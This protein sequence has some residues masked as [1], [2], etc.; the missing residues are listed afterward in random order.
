MPSFAKHFK[1]SHLSD[2]DV[3]IRVHPQDADTQEPAH[4]RAK[5]AANEQ[6]QQLA[7]FPAHQLVLCASEYF[8]AQVSILQKPGKLAASQL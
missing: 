5:I 8:N 1:D 6:L 7:A 4:K 2:C 3:V